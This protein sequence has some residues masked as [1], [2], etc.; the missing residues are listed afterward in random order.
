MRSNEFS[1]SI[2]RY[3]ELLVCGEVV[4]PWHT[5]LT[6]TDDGNLDRLLSTVGV[7]RVS[8]FRLLVCACDFVWLVISQKGLTTSSSIVRYP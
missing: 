5:L 3:R 4:S 6:G 1:F 7:V 2:D 8:R